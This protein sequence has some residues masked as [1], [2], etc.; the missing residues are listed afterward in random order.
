MEKDGKRFRDTLCIPSPG[1][2][3]SSEESP[4][5]V[6]AY[7]SYNTA[8][9]FQACNCNRRVRTGATGRSSCVEFSR[10]SRKEIAASLN[11][12]QWIEGRQAW[13][14]E[15]RAPRWVTKSKVHDS[16]LA[17]AKMLDVSSFRDDVH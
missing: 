2:M 11:R 8:C 12:K 1:A 4:C 10:C 3:Q 5:H 13:F 9:N 14:S 17:I 6:I 15:E 16:P 7:T